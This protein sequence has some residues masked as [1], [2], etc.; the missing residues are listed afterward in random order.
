MDA[1]IYSLTHVHSKRD[2]LCLLHNRTDLCGRIAHSNI[3]AYYA[4][5]HCQTYTRTMHA[6]R[7]CMH[8]GCQL[9]LRNLQASLGSPISHLLCPALLRY[10]SARACQL[11]CTKFNMCERVYICVFQELQS[12]TSTPEHYN[13]GH[14]YGQLICFNT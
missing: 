8:A 2:R 13:C 5:M 10:A 11:I 1:Y 6:C 9:T 14:I 3:H 7:G 12:V 4:R